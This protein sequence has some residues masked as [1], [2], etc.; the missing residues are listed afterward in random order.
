MELPMFIRKSVK[1]MVTYDGEKL[2][3]PKTVYDDSWA[4]EDYVDRY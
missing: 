1:A 2:A 3:I 4:T